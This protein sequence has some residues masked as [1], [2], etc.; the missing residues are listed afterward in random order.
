[1]ICKFFASYYDILIIQYLTPVHIILF[2]LYLEIIE[3][4]FCKLNY[5]TRKNIEKRRVDKIL[6][7]WAF[8]I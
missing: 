4:G 7:N 6:Q 1:M 2:L 3:L 8:R 5:N